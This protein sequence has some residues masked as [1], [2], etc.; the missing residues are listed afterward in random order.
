MYPFKK[1]V[2]KGSVNRIKLVLSFFQQKVIENHGLR[3]TVNSFSY[4]LT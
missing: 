1:L 2:K 3:Y 4:I